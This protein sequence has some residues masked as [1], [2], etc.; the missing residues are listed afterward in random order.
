MIAGVRE[1]DP[2]RDRVVGLERLVGFD[3]IRLE[4]LRLP[5][6]VEPSNRQNSSDIARAS[7]CL[8]L[9]VETNPNGWAPFWIGYSRLSQ[10]STHAIS[11]WSR[12]LRTDPIRWSIHE[13]S[14]VGAGPFAHTLCASNSPS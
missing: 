9:R 4:H 3:K 5:G 14:I 6:E 7:T 8:P 1:H 11:S 10:S 2:E 13:L 12:W